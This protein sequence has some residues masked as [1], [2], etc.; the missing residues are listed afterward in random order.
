[1]PY[2]IQSY[3]R[4]GRLDLLL[5]HPVPPSFQLAGERGFN[6]T[7]VGSVVVGITIIFY[8]VTSRE[9]Q[10]EFWWGFYIPLAIISG[11][12]LLSSIVLMVACLAFRFTSVQAIIYPVNWFADSA[13]YPIVIYAVLIQFVLTWILPYAM[14]GFYPAAFL[15][16]G[17]EFR[18]YGLLTPLMGLALFA[19]ALLTWHVASRRYQSSGT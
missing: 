14:I 16:R 4:S 13:Q 1:M 17:G 7:M 11:S 8:A 2:A 19:L 5:I 12:F 6:T 3:V 10:A 15:L 9:I 18:L